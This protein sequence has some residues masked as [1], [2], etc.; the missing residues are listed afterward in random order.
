MTP[1][2]ALAELLLLLLF[3]EL[4]LAP[5]VFHLLLQIFGTNYLTP[6]DMRKLLEHFVLD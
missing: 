6:F 5:D 1:Y 4:L 3:H 2:S